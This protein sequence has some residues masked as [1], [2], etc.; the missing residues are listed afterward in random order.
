[1]GKRKI[2]SKPGHL[3][4]AK[5]LLATRS[6]SE[7]GRQ[8]E[9]ETTDAL[10]LDFLEKQPN[11]DLQ[12]AEQEKEGGESKKG[13]QVWQQWFSGIANRLMNQM[14]LQVAVRGEVSR[15]R[16]C[17]VEFYL[18]CAGHTD[19]FSHRDELQRASSGQWY[20][21]RQNGKSY[22][23]GTYKGLDITFG[24]K[25]E[26]FGGVLIRS[27]EEEDVAK[28][29]G[30]KT[31]NAKGKQQLK[32][33]KGSN[34]FVEGPCRVVDRLLLAAQVSSIQELVDIEGFSLSVCDRGADQGDDGGAKNFRTNNF[35]PLSLV[36]YEPKKEGNNVLD[37]DIWSSPR[38]VENEILFFSFSSFFY[39]AQ[40]R[41][42]LTL[43]R[44]DEHKGHFIMQN[45]RY[46]IFS[47][48]LTSLVVCQQSRLTGC[49]RS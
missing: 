17:E 13:E 29:V 9:P 44:H 31:I 3:P 45:Y 35:L 24:S 38:C 46:V 23:G 1:M 2:S 16:I 34:T 18:H 40:F 33:G 47:R 21:H 48:Y 12:E 49:D 14:R 6:A 20:F 27:I 32:L 4:A 42:G 39:S 37:Q 41:V 10:F 5:R 11:S 43:K 30:K 25:G 26:A 22:K 7:P 19:T 8:Q 36:R 15:F 28:T